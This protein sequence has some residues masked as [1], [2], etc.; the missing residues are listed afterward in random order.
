MA[1]VGDADAKIAQESAA[2][3]GQQALGS[4]VRYF[5]GALVAGTTVADP[6]CFNSTLRL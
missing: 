4:A 3:I 1:P 5:A 2:A 6:S